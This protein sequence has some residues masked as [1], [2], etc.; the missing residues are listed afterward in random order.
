MKRVHVLEF[1]DLRWFPAWLRDCMTKNIAVMAGWLGVRHPLA[2][3]ISRALQAQKLSTIVDLGSGSGGVLPE[4]L[5][6]VQG[7]AGLEETC[8]ILSDKYPNQSAIQE[9]AGAHAQVRYLNESLDATQLHTAPDGLKTMVNC[10]HHLRPEQ[11]R[12]VLTSAVESKQPLLVYEMA[13][14]QTVPFAAWLLTLP[15]GLTIVFF[16]A[17]VKS[18]FARPFTWR[19]FVF[20]YLIPL[21]PLFYAWDGQASMPRIYGFEDLKELLQDLEND[22]YTWEMGYGESAAGKKLGSYLLGMP[23]IDMSA[24]D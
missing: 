8:L 18:A 3:L 24:I 9:Y 23:R 19:Q 4:T 20:T 22:D 17:C 6:E 21:I 16:M 12:D 10:F 2:R 5:P 11:A 15:L 14:H 7:T 1:E 13:G